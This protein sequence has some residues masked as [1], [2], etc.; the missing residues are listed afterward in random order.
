MIELLEPHRWK[1]LE[2]EF[3]EEFDAVLPDAENANIVVK[4]G[5]GGNIKGFA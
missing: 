1:E 5:A 3:A 4:F 2:R